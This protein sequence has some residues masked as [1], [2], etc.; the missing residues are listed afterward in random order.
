MT[1]EIIGRFF[2]AE[3]NPYVLGLLR[4]AVSGATDRSA[5]FTFN[6]F[7]VLVGPEVVRIEDVLDPEQQ[8]EVPIELFAERL[9]CEE[10][11]RH[12][13]LKGQ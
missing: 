8:T 3:G 13:P 10:A 2:E 11:A 6:V 7:D 12:R 9:A 5:T 1:E 4:E